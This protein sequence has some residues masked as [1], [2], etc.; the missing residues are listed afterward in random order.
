MKKSFN[1]LNELINQLNS[2][3]KTLEEHI[4]KLSNVVD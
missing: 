4:N 1:E 2:K 3:N